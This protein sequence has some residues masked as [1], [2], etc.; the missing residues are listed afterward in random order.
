MIIFNG[1]A[2][3]Q[4]LFA[5]LPAVLVGTF[6]GCLGVDG[7]IPGAIAFLASCAAL[8]AYMRHSAGQPGFDEWGDPAP[9]LGFLAYVLPWKGGHLFFLPNWM[10]GATLASLLSLTW[11]MSFFA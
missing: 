11:V 6:F 1:L 10:T 3:L 5:M 8:D 4:G 7:A 9:G 2:L